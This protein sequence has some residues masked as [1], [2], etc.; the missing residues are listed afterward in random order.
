MTVPTSADQ[1]LPA[2][3]MLIGG[4]WRDASDGARLI[5]VNPFTG[6]SWATAPDAGEPDVDAAVAAAS[7]ALS[8]PWTAMTASERGACMRRLA[9]LLRERGP[10][11]AEVETTDNGKLLREMSGQMASLPDWYDYFGGLAD[12]IE[13]ATPPPTKANVFTY[14]R[15]EPIGVVGAILPWNSPL[16]LMSFKVAPA[17]AAGCT[18]VVKPAEQTPISTLAF[19]QLFEEAGFPPGVFNV[20]TGGRTAGARLVSHPDVAKIAFTGSTEIGIHVMKSAAD[21]LARVTL[22]LGGK[23]PNI[24][25]DDADLDA[26][27]NGVLSGIYAASGQTCIAGSRL[28]VQRTIHDELVARVAARAQTIR[29]GDPL[30]LS[31]EMGPCATIEQLEK[32]MLF[33]ERA[34]ADGLKVLCGG[35]RPTA[36]ELAEGYF[37]EPTIVTGANNGHEIAR[38]EIF[39]PVLTVIPFDS[40]AEA[41]EIAND[42]RFG[43]G[44]GVWTTDIKRAHR[45]AH[46][47]RA[48]SVW[49]NCYRMLTYNMPFGGYKMSGI[50]RENGM[51][52]VHE[53][54]ETK[55]VWIDLS[56]ESRDPFVM[57]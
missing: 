47:I 5:T 35:Q 48:G 14:T 36:P 39:G 12:K 3:Q 13:G 21:H 23:S 18:V 26:A 34:R 29:L 37:Y 57:G 8:G 44:A 43:L 49:V 32:V 9:Q 25:F 4:E 55:G 52:A 17:L 19:A 11:L 1:Q 10:A 41:I 15:H 53:Y 27:T 50:G 51:D 56:N 54:T 40:E 31:S 2:Y 45:M 42:T 38:E 46:A 20:V 7:A 30:D 6:K 28:L 22:E 16:L 24:V 33:V